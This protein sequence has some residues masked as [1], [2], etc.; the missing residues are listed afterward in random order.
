MSGAAEL[1]TPRLLLRAAR[2]DDA[3]LHRRLWEERDARVPARRRIDADDRPGVEDLA[4]AIRTARPAYGLGL[5]TIEHGSSAIGYCG[6][7]ENPLV[8]PGEPELAYELL[9]ECWGRGYATE[10]ASTVVGRTRAAGFDRIW[11]TVRR[12]NLPSLRVAEKLGFVESGRVDAD[13]VHG[14]SLH[15]VLRLRG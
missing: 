8:P 2:S 1:R 13:D 7:V 11:A 4:V 3:G 10:A 12:W 6:L 9:R 15:L 14:D 5:L